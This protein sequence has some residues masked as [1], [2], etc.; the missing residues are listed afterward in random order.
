[1]LRDSNL[2]P[3]SHQHHNALVMC[4]LTRRSLGQDASAANVAQLARRAIDRYELELVNHFE[5]EEQIL[6]PA[7]ENSLGKLP[8]VALLIAQHRQLEDL[9]AQLRSAPTTALLERL[10]G[11]LTEHIRSEESDL[12]Q[13]VQSRLPE[14]ILREL[15]EAIERLV[16]RVCL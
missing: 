8:L 4:V 14:P 2:I 16:V 5:I 6:F 3:L 10:C 7:I 9:V 15:G 1:M 13:T 11:L 12:F